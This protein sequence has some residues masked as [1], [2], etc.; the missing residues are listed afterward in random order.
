MRRVRSEPVAS[1]GE[2]DARYAIITFHPVAPYHR[3]DILIK[4]KEEEKREATCA[5]GSVQG[6]SAH[7]SDILT[8][9][10]EGNFTD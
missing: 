3:R 2:R 9:R 7:H 1:G 10:H 6:V 8:T 5:N 4:E